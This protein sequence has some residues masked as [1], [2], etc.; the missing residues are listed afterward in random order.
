[1][2]LKF[3]SFPN[4]GLHAMLCCAFNNFIYIVLHKKLK[5]IK[6]GKFQLRMLIGFLFEIERPIVLK[7][8]KY[9][10]GNLYCKNVKLFYI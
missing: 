5:Q 1:M 10:K 3:W 9:L 2:F 8:K 4:L 6:F 7:T